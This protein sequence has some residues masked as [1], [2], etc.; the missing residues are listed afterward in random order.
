MTNGLHEDNL[1]HALDRNLFLK[2]TSSTA[3]GKIYFP[4]LTN[5]IIITTSKRRLMIVEE[6]TTHCGRRIQQR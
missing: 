4:R 3:C 2:Q 5:R 1:G 6:T